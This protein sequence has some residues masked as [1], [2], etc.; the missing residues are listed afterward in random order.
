MTCESYNPAKN[1]SIFDY[2]LFKPLENFFSLY[3]NIYGNYY[4]QLYLSFLNEFF[5]FNCELLKIN[6]GF[7]Q[8]GTGHHISKEY[9]F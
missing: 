7:I 9:T 8:V 4:M 6:S 1:F 5:I 2:T 3:T